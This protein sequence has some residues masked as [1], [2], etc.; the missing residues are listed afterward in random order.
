[1]EIIFSK[2]FYDYDM[3]YNKKNL[4]LDY[5]IFNNIDI[6]IIELN[7]LDCQ[8]S[9][10]KIIEYTLNNNKNVKIIKTILFSHSL[11]PTNILLE[12]L[13]K[14]ILINLNIDLDKYN[15]NYKNEII[16]TWNNA[17][18]RKMI[19]DLNIQ[20]KINVDDKF[21]KRRYRRNKNKVILN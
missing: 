4:I 14:Y 11:H 6:L 20:F 12:K 19:K 21:Y 7:N 1:M 13:W 3:K 5:N 18:T 8:A 16:T 17:F 15:F 9:S 10:L 2:V